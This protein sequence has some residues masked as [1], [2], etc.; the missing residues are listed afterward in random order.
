[1]TRFDRGSVAADA[2]DAVGATGAAHLIYAGAS[3]RRDDR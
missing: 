3:Q 1:M 2:I